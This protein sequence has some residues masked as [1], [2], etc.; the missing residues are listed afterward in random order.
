ALV[1]NRKPAAVS[2]VPVAEGKAAPHAGKRPPVAKIDNPESTTHAAAPE[3]VAL[4]TPPPP[5]PTEPAVAAFPPPPAAQGA[6]P[7]VPDPV[8]E[9]VRL[10]MASEHEPTV[11][12]SVPAAPEPVQADSPRQQ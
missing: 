1:L 11:P 8:A 12:P 7:R 6:V 2:P 9:P 4:E 10:A 5:L 3:R